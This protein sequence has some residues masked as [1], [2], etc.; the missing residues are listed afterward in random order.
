MVSV[1]VALI[2]LPAADGLHEPRRYSPLSEWRIRVPAPETA[3]ALV[4]QL[5]IEA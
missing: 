3:S 2:V 4:T 5:N 1:I